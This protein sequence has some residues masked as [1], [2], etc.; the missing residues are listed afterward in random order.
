MITVGVPWLTV[1]IVD[2]YETDASF[3]KPPSEQAAIGKMAFAIG[4]SNSRRFFP[5]V[6]CIS[7]GE[8]HPVGRFHCLDASL[9]GIF[10]P[11]LSGKVLAV[12]RM[13]EIELFSL[14][15]WVEL[16]VAQPRDHFLRS[17]LRVVYVDALML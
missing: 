5:Q 7:G 6:K 3:G 12:E 1:S 15:G 2:L 11:S 10:V 16:W 14:R 17:N 4:F 13:H 8:L 9:Q